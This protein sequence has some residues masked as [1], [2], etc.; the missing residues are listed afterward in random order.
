MSVRREA[1]VQP[2]E[3]ILRG[4][5]IEFSFAIYPGQPDALI[6]QRHVPEGATS[7]LGQ[8][9]RLSHVLRSSTP[10]RAF[11]AAASGMIRDHL[12]RH[13]LK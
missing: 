5:L 4:E 9:E 2:R 11:L 12:V 8:R 7:D 1:N 10:R 13:C 3:R 6:A